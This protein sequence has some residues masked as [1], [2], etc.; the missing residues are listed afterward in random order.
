MSYRESETLEL[1]KSTA[2]LKEAV[3]SI[4]AILNKHGQGEVYFGIKDDSTIVGQMVGKDT[5]KDV[6]QAITDNL[7]PKVFPKIEQRK[8]EGKDCIVVEFHGIHQ[9]YFAYGRAYMRVGESDKH[10]TAREIEHFIRKQKRWLWENEV[11]NKKLTD[12]NAATVKEYMRKANAAKRINFKYT[13]VKTTLGKL[14]LLVGG[15]LTKAAEVLFCKNTPIEVQAAVFAGTDKNTFLDI[16]KFE[17]NIFKLRARAELY[18]KEHLKW[19]A[20]MSQSRRTE[21]PEIPI[22]AFSEA[23]GNSLCHRDYTDP[24][25]VEVAIFK[26]RVDI[27]NPGTFPEELTPEDFIKGGGYSILRNPLIAETMYK[28]EDIEKWASGLKRIYDECKAA[29]VK[30]EF[31]QV[32]TGFVVSFKRPKWEEGEALPGRVTESIPES[33]P[34]RITEKQKEILGMMRVNPHISTK[35]IANGVG[36]AERNIKVHVKKLKAMKKLKRVGPDKGGHWEV[37]V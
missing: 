20:D 12:V 32:K 37:V 3:I 14:G 9:P 26:D 8:I 7:D 23:I 24:K 17:G 36:I 35:E 19:R 30:V 16:S 34:E 25:G 6:T 21:I 28:S 13:D 22:R 10:L 18:L 4:S 33:I 1:K 29:G 15:K 2:E 27:Y 5:I 31:K 11:S